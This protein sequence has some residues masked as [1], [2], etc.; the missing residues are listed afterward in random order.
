MGSK[1]LVVHGDEFDYK[2]MTYSKEAVLEFNIFSHSLGILTGQ[3]L[4]RLYEKS[5]IKAIL[6]MNW[7]MIGFRKHWR[8]IAWLF[9]T[10]SESIFWIYDWIAVTK[11]D[12]YLTTL[13]LCDNPFL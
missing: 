6:L 3:P 2:N 7:Y 13:K 1:I 8:L 12:Y 11:K 4:W 5:V 10:N 9:Y